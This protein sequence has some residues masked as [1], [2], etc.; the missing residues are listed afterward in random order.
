[1]KSFVRACH[2]NGRVHLRIVSGRRNVV[3][4]LH[5]DEAKRISAILL[6]LANRAEPKALKLHSPEVRV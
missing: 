3:I 6:E 4:P 1:M 5:P 2:R